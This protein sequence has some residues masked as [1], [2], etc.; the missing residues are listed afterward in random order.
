MRPLLALALLTLPAWAEQIATTTIEWIALSPESHALWVEGTAPDGPMT[1]ELRVADDPLV[2]ATRETIAS[3]G[4]F[5]SLLRPGRLPAACY[6]LEISATRAT[7]RFGVTRGTEEERDAYSK[8]ESAWLGGA[9]DRIVKL[10]D[11]LQRVRADC[12][13]EHSLERWALWSPGWESRRVSLAREL[14]DFRAGRGVLGRAREFYR[15]VSSLCFAKTLHDLYAAELNSR[16]GEPGGAE[17]SD[18]SAAL[19]EQLDGFREARTPVTAEDIARWAEELADE[20]ALVRERASHGLARAGE[21]A[22]AT[23]VQVRAGRDREAAARARELLQRLD[24]R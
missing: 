23:L 7:A 9:Y 20:D 14:E 10:T 13:P 16:G 15:L 2:V 21:A 11:E 18:W 19:S 8:P 17:A 24:R 5:S 4:R 3:D 6:S 22:R 1:L 12:L